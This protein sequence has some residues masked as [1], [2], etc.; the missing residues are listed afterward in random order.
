MERTTEQ[1]IISDVEQL[2]EKRSTAMADAVWF[3]PT[4]HYTEPARLRREREVLF[5]KY[6]HVAA[7]GAQIPNPG[8][9]IT[10]KIADV[11]LIV[12]RG[13]DGQARC[14]VNI[15]RH[16][17]NT[18]CSESHGTK[19]MFAC[20]YH[21]WTYDTTGKCRSFVD[22]NGFGDI[23]R[24]DYG[25]VSLPCEERYG[26]VW[27]IPDPQSTIDMAT[28]VGPEFD[29]ELL[30]YRIDEQMVY[31]DTELHKP[32]NWKLGVDTFHEVFHLA[33]LHKATVGPLFLGN[34]S[35]YEKIGL[36]HRM[37][38]IRSTFPDMLAKPEDEQH[39]L[40]NTGLVYFIFPATF[41]NW[42]M[43][44]MEV[45]SVCPEAGNDD[46]CVIKATMLIHEPPSTPSAARHWERNW[47]V[48]SESVMTEDFD[49]MEQI[50]AN[51]ESGLVSELP[52]GR[53]EIGLQNFHRDVNATLAEHV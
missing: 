42:Q 30:D 46:Q 12:V 39:L 5:R 40:P 49:T 51:I 14:L 15:C 36:H 7:V 32:F 44:H 6:P 47:T 48:L 10:T 27:C 43:D 35:S 2:L 24:A 33:F 21:A 50:Q 53:N 29:T 18:V 37:A 1:A 31:A 16:R 9:F 45:W 8:D 3:E 13:E 38:A 41:I 28:Y 52:F 19:R 17:A 22:R 26:F 11:P 4:T 25:L 34:V 23:E 20:Q